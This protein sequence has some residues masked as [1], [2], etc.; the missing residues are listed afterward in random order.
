MTNPATGLSYGRS[1]V[2]GVAFAVGWTPC[3]GPI[4]GS[5]LTLAASSGTVLH[6]TLLLTFWSLGLGVPFLITGF[7][8][9]S[10]MRF[11]R[12][13]RPLMP[14]LEVGGGVLVILVGVL[15]FMDQFTVFNRYFAGGVTRVTS[16]EGQLSFIDITGR[17]GSS[18]LSSPASSPFSRPAACQWSPRTSCT[19][20]VLPAMR[21][22]IA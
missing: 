12:R 16:A 4:L 2:V 11:I 10:V 14:V 20:L 21:E 17:S 19:S 9:E 7:A 13:I 5:V 22:A 15:I 6:G 3:L 1:G 18:Q 8:L